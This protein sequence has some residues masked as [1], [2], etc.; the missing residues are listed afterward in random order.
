MATGRNE[1]CPCG[2]GR[3]YKNCH[4]AAD[5]TARTSPVTL[6][7]V[8]V[9]LLVGLLLAGRALLGPTAAGPDGPAP[10]GKVWSEE[11]GHWH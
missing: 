1:P 3:K 11:H 4:G 6:V 7:V 9:A 2:S 8:G 5:A 10:D